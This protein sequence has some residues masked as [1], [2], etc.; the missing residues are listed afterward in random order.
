MTGKGSG[1]RACK[2]KHIVKAKK[3][4]YCVLSNVFIWIPILFKFLY[5]HQRYRQRSQHDPLWCFR[6]TTN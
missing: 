6:N 4:S 1:L 5:L 3:K 2:G